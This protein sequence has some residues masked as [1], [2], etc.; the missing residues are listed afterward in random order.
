ME[1]VKRSIQSEGRE[2][3]D[4][5]SI[6]FSLLSLFS[7]RIHFRV[8]CIY[9]CKFKSPSQSWEFLSPPKNSQSIKMFVYIAC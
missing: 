1:L 4:N 6:N 3:R 2:G 5:G 7:L 8:V 9:G